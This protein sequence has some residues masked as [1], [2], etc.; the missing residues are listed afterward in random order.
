M[1][2]KFEPICWRDKLKGVTKNEGQQK[3]P[4]GIIC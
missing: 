2:V 4:I 3:L 1:I